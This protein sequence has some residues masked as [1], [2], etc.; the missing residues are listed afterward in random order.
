M[1]LQE[2]KKWF[3]SLDESIKHNMITLMFRLCI[4][5]KV[6]N[7]NLIFRELNEQIISLQETNK[8]LISENK[9]LVHANNIFQTS[10]LGTIMTSIKDVEQNL[11]N[12]I[13]SMSLKITPSVNGKFGEDY[14]D[15]ILSKIPNSELLN[16]SQ[17]KGSGD[18]IFKTGDYRIMIESKNWTNSSIK[19]NP[20][21]LVQFKDTAIESFENGEVD[22]AIMAL[23]RVTDLKG[24]SIDTETIYT[25]RGSMFII[26][27]TN[28]I[29]HPERILY[30]I[31]AGIMLFQQKTNQSIDIDKFM[32]QVD[33]F[34]KNLQFL[35]DSLKE[36]LKQ[37]KDMSNT[38]KN[39]SD[40][41][42]ELKDM[43]N[44]IVKHEFVGIKDRIINY[45]KELID[46]YGEH[47]VTKT[48]LENRCNEKG[49]SARYIREYGGIKAIKFLCTNNPK[50][51]V[52]D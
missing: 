21:E 4:S 15:N 32:Y 38:V 7:T 39:D 24:K 40:K 26:T 43:L 6:D 2:A 20:K 14:I 35:E 30:A 29:N 10:S 36:R 50:K 44:T 8:H 5:T 41:I 19:G 34:L 51:I 3:N 47:S 42:V 52:V 17:Q 23:H 16:V 49:I 9:N 25:K 45:C 22:F 13:N 48:M 11:N 28:I 27:I 33:F 1:E 31:D 12:A 46:E 37:I 18:F